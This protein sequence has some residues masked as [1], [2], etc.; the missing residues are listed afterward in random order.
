MNLSNE[1]IFHDGFL[2]EGLNWENLMSWSLFFGYT[3]RTVKLSM[4]NRQQPISIKIEY[5]EQLHAKLIINILILR[6]QG[7]YLTQALFPQRM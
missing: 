3:L 6:F 2:R 1:H 7:D 4:G 5:K